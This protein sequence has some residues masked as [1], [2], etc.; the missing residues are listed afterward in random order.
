[1]DFDYSVTLYDLTNT[2]FESTGQQLSAGEES[3]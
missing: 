2:F 1:L 3:Q